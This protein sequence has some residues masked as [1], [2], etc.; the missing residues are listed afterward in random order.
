M[1]D[2]ELTSISV[3]NVDMPLAEQESRLPEHAEYVK[4][5]Y[6][7]IYVTIQGN[8]EKPAFITFTDIGL[9]CNHKLKIKS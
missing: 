9:N 6:G 1:A 5:R 2:V 7:N 4:T 8:R 3:K